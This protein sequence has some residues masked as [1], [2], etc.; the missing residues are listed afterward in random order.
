MSIFKSTKLSDFDGNRRNNFTSIRLLFA[1]LVLYG[2]AYAIQKTPGYGDV[3]NQFFQGSIW[4]GEL[5]VDGFFA[6][7]GFLV[8]ASFMKRGLFDY[9]I[10]RVLR[11]M[12]ALWVCVLVCAF[13]IG[14]FFTSLTVQEY[15]STRETFYFLRNLVG[16]HHMIVE[17]PGLFESNV[18]PA[19]NGSLWTLAIEIRV[20]LL[21]AICGTL[22][23]L[24]KRW[25]ANMVLISV[26]FIEL[27]IS[28]GIPFFGKGDIWGLTGRYFAVGVF[29]YINRDKVW[30]DARL[31][32]LALLLIG[33]SFGKGWFDAVFPI[34]FVYLIFFVAYM[35]KY[36]DLDGKIGD[37]SYG[38]YIYAWPTQQIVAHYFPDFTPGQNTLLSTPIVFVFAYASWRLV[39]AP[40]LGLKKKLLG[41][42]R[43]KFLRRKN[44]ESGGGRET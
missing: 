29:F 21:L 9:T 42:T 13:V 7:S 22:G 25:I 3:L 8:A 32:L 30:L 19:V 28:P 26:F 44:L 17:L 27:F 14:P 35:T 39:E 23:L 41:A 12:P 6:I 16:F 15:F 31:A 36:I 5:A 37:L 20:Y 1:W 10:S 38:V 2:H 34:P 11:I 18:R 24:S 40:T 4:I 43:F 33:V